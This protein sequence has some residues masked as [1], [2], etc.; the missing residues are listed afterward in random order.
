MHT[1]KRVEQVNV[2]GRHR[3]SVMALLRPRLFPSKGV[4]EGCTGDLRAGLD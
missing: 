4:G 3:Y 1:V 2:K